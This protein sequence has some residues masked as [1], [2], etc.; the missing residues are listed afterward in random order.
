MYTDKSSSHEE[1]SS[2]K[3]KGIKF[4]IQFSSKQWNTI[5]PIEV[6]YVRKHKASH[7]SGVRKYRSLQPGL[8]TEVFSKEIAKRKDIPCEFI[9]KNNKCYSTGETFVFKAS[10]QFALLYL[11]L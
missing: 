6:S 8:W 3:D 2:P 4:N 10:V 5:K 7:K 9:F 11:L 1:F